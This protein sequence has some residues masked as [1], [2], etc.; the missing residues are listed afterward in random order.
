MTRRPHYD[1]LPFNP[2]IVI[3]IMFLCTLLAVEWPL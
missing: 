3:A 1:N 2:W